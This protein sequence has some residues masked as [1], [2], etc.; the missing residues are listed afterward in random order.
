VL[1]DI[2][3]DGSVNVNFEKRRDETHLRIK[4]VS[5]I[6]DAKV[7][8]LASMLSSMETRAKS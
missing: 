4:A 1:V 5:L 2:S 3:V 8:T 6:S 7:E